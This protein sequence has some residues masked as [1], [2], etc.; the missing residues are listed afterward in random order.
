[1][2]KRNKELVFSPE[3]LREEAIR[4]A[5]EEVG[6]NP[7]FDSD[8]LNRGPHIRAISELLKTTEG[9]FVMTLSSPWGTGK[10]TFI[11]MWKAYLEYKTHPCVLFNAWE[12]DYAD[13]PFLTFIAEMYEQLSSLKGKDAS[14]IA[15]T[16]EEVKDFGKKLLPRMLSFGTKAAIGFSVDFES[17]GKELACLDSKKSNDLGSQLASVLSGATEAYASEALESH[18]STK[19]M[20]KEFKR[21]LGKLVDALGARQR[22]MYFFVDELDRCKPSY[23]V[24]LLEAVKHLFDIPGIVFVL[25]LDREQLG[26]SVK[27]AYGQDIDSEG[28][29]RRFI[30][31]EYR[32][33]V[34]DRGDFVWQL[35]YDYGLDQC[36]VFANDTEEESFSEFVREFCE[37]AQHCSLRTI[38]KVL[39]R[40]SVLIRGMEPHPTKL[41]TSRIL[42]H[43]MFLRELRPKGFD[44][45]LRGIP[46]QK[47]FGVGGVLP[48]E[49]LP[50]GLDHEKLELWVKHK[51]QSE[52]GNPKSRLVDRN[53][54]LSDDLDFAIS[55]KFE[56]GA[57]L[58]DVIKQY[59]DLSASLVPTAIDTDGFDISE[60]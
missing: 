3:D 14:A 18:Q 58:A 7:W 17:I 25:S 54:D 12:H 29:L 49:E 9:N 28:Y 59:L 35:A 19:Q 38:E 41:T 30:D 48:E 37:I 55:Y 43:Y 44:L 45:I 32:I 31:L 22:P 10:T 20:V 46:V 60:L 53:H 6:G 5:E 4:L 36:R 1:M 56:V 2:L 40:G 34:P 21:K 27:A 11:R 24:E 8:L 33:P 16:L 52:S 51:Q 50:R 57:H 15:N 13:N 26:H 23:A 42:A 39:L 47:V